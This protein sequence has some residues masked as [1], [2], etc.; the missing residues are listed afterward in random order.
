[1]TRK[2]QRADLEREKFDKELHS[3]KVDL[4]HVP[5]SEIDYNA[6]GCISEVRFYNTEDVL[7]KKTT[8]TYDPIFTDRITE[9]RNEF[10]VSS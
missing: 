5:R 6:T 9:V 8:L 2:N 1:M 7:V 3:V 10:Y 4:N